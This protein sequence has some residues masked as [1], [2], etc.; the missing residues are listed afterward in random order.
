MPLSQQCWTCYH[1]NNGNGIWCKHTTISNP[2][3]ASHIREYSVFFNPQSG[4]TLLQLAQVM[5]KYV[6][7]VMATDTTADCFFSIRH[8]I[9]RGTMYDKGVA[10]FAGNYFANKVLANKEKFTIQA[11][12]AVRGALKCAIL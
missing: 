9:I 1:H 8:F 11:D 3:T 2:I 12:Y 5:E 7:S 6:I 10:A 4:V